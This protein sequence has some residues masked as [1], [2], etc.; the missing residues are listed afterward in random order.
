MYI[1]KRL[2]ELGEERK[3]K[4]EHASTDTQKSVVNSLFYGAMQKL[5]IVTR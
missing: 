1:E 5:E 3:K 4:F 2:V